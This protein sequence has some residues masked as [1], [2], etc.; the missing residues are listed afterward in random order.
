[1]DWTAAQDPHTYR[2]HYAAGTMLQLG[3]CGS[4]RTAAAMYVDAGTV[5]Y[6]DASGQLFG[7]ESGGPAWKHCGG[8]PP[9]GC[10]GSAHFVANI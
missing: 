7:V 1:M 5:F 2:K 4:V 10:I 9:V 8:S 3:Q 6:F